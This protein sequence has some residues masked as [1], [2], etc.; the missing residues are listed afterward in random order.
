MAETGLDT[1]DMADKQELTAWACLMSAEQRGEVISRYEQLLQKYSAP[2]AR[3]ADLPYP[4][5]LIRRAIREE[6]SENPDFEMRSYLEIAFVQLECFLPPEEFKVVHDFK[7][8]SALA[9]ELAKSGDPRDIVASAG[10]LSKVKGDKAV[11]ILEKISRKIRQRIAEIRA[12]S[13]PVFKT[14]EY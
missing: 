4:K 8:A 7:R 10:I 9:Q 14:T 13:L 12:I 2:V 1:N 6:L 11:R 3:E 5:K